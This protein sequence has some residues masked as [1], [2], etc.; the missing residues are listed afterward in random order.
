MMKW[1]FIAMVFFIPAFAL[2]LTGDT[3]KDWI[4]SVCGFIL[5]FL[6]SYIVLYPDDPWVKRGLDWF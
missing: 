5:G 1:I 4:N 3:P 2:A 6:V